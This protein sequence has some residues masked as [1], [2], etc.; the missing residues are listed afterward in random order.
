MSN[1]N[2]E[3]IK[4]Y[5]NDKVIIKTFYTDREG[6][7][8]EGIVNPLRIDN[9]QLMSP[10][11]DQRQYPACAGF[12]ACTLV[13]SMYW[14]RTGKLVQLDANQVYAKAKE[15]DGSPNVEGTYLEAALHAAL[16]L[17]D[18]EFLE[19]AKV[20]TFSN[21][22][23]SDTVELTKHLIHRNDFIQVG[24][25]IDEAWYSCDN[26]NYVLKAGGR[27][28]GGHAVNVVGY[29]SDGVYVMNQWSTSWGSKGFAVMPWDLYLKEL[30]YGAYIEV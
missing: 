16:A 19:D 26:E 8:V 27:T 1:V 11:D 17:C 4:R 9:R 13:E 6:A 7:N 30:M 2:E 10:T 18:F 21:G 5:R 29:D 23:D 20:R 24:F 3:L 25:M 15:G 14:K 22:M 28:L 12:S